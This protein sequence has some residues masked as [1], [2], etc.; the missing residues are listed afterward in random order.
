MEIDS[1]DANLQSINIQLL[2]DAGTSASTAKKSAGDAKGEAD[3]A[4]TAAGDAKT[5]ASGARTE[6]DALTGEIKSAKEQAADA[7]SR[8]ADAEQR[9]ADSTQR[10]AAAEAK[11]SAIKT[12]R[13]LSNESALIAALTPFKGTEYLLNTFADAE[14]MNFTQTVGK[15]LDAAG[16]VR[17]QPKVVTLGVPTVTM[18]FEQGKEKESVP[19]CLEMGIGI[20]VRAKES[21]PTLQS[22]PF[23]N[24][25]RNVQAALALANSIVTSISPADEHNVAPGIIDPEPG[26]GLPIT[27]CVGKK[28]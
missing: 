17:K 22:T 27:I 16:W 4:K 9:L 23:P 25:P 8:L 10:E 24:L 26:E 28:P 6:A 14:S 13:S 1:D 15:T 7:V 2:R 21:L 19:S 20:H 3:Q 11:L 5:L 12:P 18:V